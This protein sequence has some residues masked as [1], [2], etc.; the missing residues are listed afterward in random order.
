MVL[1][2][3][4]IK[5]IVLILGMSF[6]QIFVYYRAMEEVNMNFSAVTL[7]LLQEKEHQFIHRF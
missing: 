1:F 6:L 7:E 3:K 5:S 4:N 2:M